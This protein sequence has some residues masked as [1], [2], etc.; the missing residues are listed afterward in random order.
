MLLLQLQQRRRAVLHL[1]L[2]QRHARR[3]RLAARRCCRGLLLPCKE[4]PAR[5]QKAALVG[6]GKAAQKGGPE[7]PDGGVRRRRRGAAPGGGVSGRAAADL[8]GR[9]RSIRE[10]AL[11]EE[12]VSGVRGGKSPRFWGARLVRRIG[13]NCASRCLCDSHGSGVPD[14]PILI[15]TFG[16]PSCFS[17]P[18]IRL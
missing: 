12:G 16:W 5:H 8:G 3:L 14:N 2:Q 18:R 10:G 7:G 17:P 15:E 4:A 6:G 13:E 1:Q 11:G 9:D